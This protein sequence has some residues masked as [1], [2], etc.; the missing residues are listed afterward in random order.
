MLAAHAAVAIENARLL[1]RSRELSIVEERNRLARE[2]HDS[3]SQKLF[4]LVLTAEAAGTLL[5]RDPE[6]AAE[7][8]DAARRAGAA[9]RSASC[10]R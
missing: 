10:A 5:D 6:A 7:Q 2:L 3:V 9:R 1:E 4:G 8:V